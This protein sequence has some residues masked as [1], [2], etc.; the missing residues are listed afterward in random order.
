MDAW[1]AAAHQHP[2]L[3]ARD[4][5]A[6]VLQDLG[7][8]PDFL[9]LVTAS[10]DIFALSYASSALVVLLHRLVECMP[11][12]IGVQPLQFLAKLRDILI[13]CALGCGELG[14][15]C[16]SLRGLALLDGMPPVKGNTTHDQCRHDQ[17]HQEFRHGSQCAC[18]FR[19]FPL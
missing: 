17:Q 4:R 8:V 1:L 13:S 18:A 16:R 3:D 11:S 6:P 2:C 9:G 5:V 7:D 12:N 19:G 10:S 14:F 15:Q